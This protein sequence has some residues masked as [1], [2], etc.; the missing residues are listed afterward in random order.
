MAGFVDDNK[1]LRSYVTVIK[2]LG[3]FQGIRSPA[4]W[5]VTDFE[6]FYYPKISMKYRANTLEVSRCLYPSFKEH[7]GEHY[8]FLRKALSALVRYANM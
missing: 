4:R 2:E 7:P 6:G 8:R 3:D 5:Y 1:Q